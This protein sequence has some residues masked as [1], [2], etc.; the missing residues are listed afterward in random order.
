VSRIHVVRQGEC[1]LTIAERHGFEDHLELH[2][3]PQNAD[4]KR[5]RPDPM[6]LKPGDCVFIPERHGAP[7]LQVAPGGRHRFRARRPLVELRAR[8]EDEAGEAI[9]GRKVRLHIGSR[10]VDASTDGDGVL[11]H[12]VPI[13]EGAV[14]AVVWLDPDDTSGDEAAP[15]AYRMVFSLGHLD[16]ASEVS[17]VQQRLANLG[18]LDGSPTGE[19]D[20]RTRA[21]ITALQR[22]AGV[23]ATGELDDATR[24]RLVDLHG[25]R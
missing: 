14:D 7:A 24:S 5:A 4:L 8:L 6:I 2:N 9:A 1:L 23:D 10:T 13:G 15:S 19:L 12:R 21:A 17:G 18:L 25:G 20:E 3:H 11:V 22:A 16:P